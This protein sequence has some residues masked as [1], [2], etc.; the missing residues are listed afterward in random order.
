[1]QSIDNVSFLLTHIVAAVAQTLVNSPVLIAYKTS[2]EMIES[3]LGM[4]KRLLR[5]CDL[6][7]PDFTVIPTA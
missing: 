2:V 4:N 5:S 1:M 6:W 7:F 3:D